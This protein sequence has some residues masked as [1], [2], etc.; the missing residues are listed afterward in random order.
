MSVR[1][2]LLGL[3]FVGA[4]I[5]PAV[6]A[7]QPLVQQPTAPSKPA[8]EPHQHHEPPARETPV[9]P[10]EREGSGTSWL[11]DASPMYAIHGSPIR[12]WQTMLHGIASI[13]YVRDEKPRGSSQFGSINW[14][15]GSLRKTGAQGDLALR[16]MFSLEPATIRGCGY[17]DLLASGEICDGH[18]IVDKQHPHDLLMEIAALYGRPLSSGLGLQLYAGLAGEPALGPVAFP[19]RPSSLANP[20]APV[21]HHWLDASHITFGV[22]TAGVHGRRWKIESSVFNGRE[23]DAHRYDLD[24]APLDSYSAR[25]AILPAPRWALQVSA[26]HLEEAEEHG[27]SREDV[28]RVTASAIYHA[29]RVDAGL[30]ATT[31]AWGRNLEDGRWTQAMLAE[32]SLSIRDRHVIF[33]RAEIVQKTSHDLEV[34]GFDDEVFTIGKVQAGYSRYFTQVAGW[35]PGVGVSMSVGVV[36]ARL[37]PTYGGRAPIGVAV[38]FA[39]R[40]AL[41]EHKQ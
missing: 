26:G 35:R 2:S 23:P 15:M 6:W 7:Q 22:V 17:P 28:D 8:E 16:G 9:I 25:V 1:V 39:L 11:P 12:E 21:S 33:C 10:H 4:T 29:P 34:P 5:P 14:L 24:L 19:H 36:P 40:P 3:I 32:S 38:F 31:L 13:Q 30:L 27:S 20:L 41:G 37:G 18:E